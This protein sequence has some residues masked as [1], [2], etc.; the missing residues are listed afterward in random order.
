MWDIA[1]G[2]G[3]FPA[4]ISS[5]NLMLPLLLLLSSHASTAVQQKQP[6]R[7]A[8]KLAVIGMAEVV[9]N[10][11]R[12]GCIEPVGGALG[13]NG[14]S[15]PIAWHNPLTNQS[16]LISATYRGTYASVGPDLYGKLRH[17][18]R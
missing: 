17:D 14:D 3:A 1:L 10:R 4:H 9:W 15:V 5:H 18:C 12:D 6:Y 11:S 16:Y 8:A 13:E 2:G 7:P